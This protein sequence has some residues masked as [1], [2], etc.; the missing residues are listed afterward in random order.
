MRRGRSNLAIKPL[1]DV[2]HK[3][4]AELRNQYDAFAAYVA[5][6][7]G[8]GPEHFPVYCWTKARIKDSEKKAAHIKTFSLHVQGREVCKKN[9]ADALEADLPPLVSAGLITNFSK[10][11]INP[12]FSPQAPAHM[13]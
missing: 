13:A 9:L 10:F 6:A 1:T 7:E 4:R 3:H 12:A 11:F 8:L 5:D 2:L